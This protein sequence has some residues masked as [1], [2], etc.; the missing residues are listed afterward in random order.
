MT[1]GW[2][3]AITHNPEEDYEIQTIPYKDTNVIEPTWT[4]E[5]YLTQRWTISELAKGHCHD[6]NCAGLW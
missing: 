5:L 4:V 6:K 1:F 3:S 2:L